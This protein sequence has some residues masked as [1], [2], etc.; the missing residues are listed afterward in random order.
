MGA[1]GWPV[2]ILQGISILFVCSIQLCFADVFRSIIPDGYRY[3]AIES[4]E[5]AQ[6]VEIRDYMAFKALADFRANGF[7]QYHTFE[8]ALSYTLKPLNLDRFYFGT[9]YELLWEDYRPIS[10]KL[11]RVSISP[12]T[13]SDAI[14]FL[15][16][17]MDQDTIEELRRGVVPHL[18]FDEIICQKP[19]RLRES[20]AID[21]EEKMR[22]WFDQMKRQTVLLPDG[23]HVL[24]LLPFQYVVASS[25]ELHYVKIGR[26]YVWLMLTLNDRASGLCKKLGLGKLTSFRLKLDYTEEFAHLFVFQSGSSRAGHM[27]PASYLPLVR[28]FT[29]DNFLVESLSEDEMK[30][31]GYLF[32]TTDLVRGPEPKWFSDLPHLMLE[33]IQCAT[34]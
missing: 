14:G 26:R 9:S 24:D 18:L 23:T 28:N 12:V 22:N 7:C 34:L 3:L 15:E 31:F 25:E 17:D 21:P 11:E 2:K 20:A 32:K 33:K 30:M 19:E 10:E 13:A 8:K 16:V 6:A 27:T 4:G 29:K 1:R 5:F